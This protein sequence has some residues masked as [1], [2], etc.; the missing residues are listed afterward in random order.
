MLTKRDWIAVLAVT[1]CFLAATLESELVTVLSLCATAIVLGLV[2]KLTREQVLVI[3]FGFS[4]YLVAPDALNFSPTYLAL[5]TFWLSPSFWVVIF[6]SQLL[7]RLA[8]AWLTW[9]ATLMV[10]VLISSSRHRLVLELS[11]LFDL[12]KVLFA[13]ALGFTVAVLAFNSTAAARLKLV[14]LWLVLSSSVAG[15]SLFAFFA[16][17]L[18]PSSVFE[19]FVFYNLEPNE[20]LGGSHYNARLR[21]TFEDPNLFALYLLI[22]LI[23][24]L[25]TAA[26]TVSTAS[27]TQTVALSAALSLADS[28]AATV[29]LLASI[30]FAT[31]RVL[32]LRT[33]L[34]S[35]LLWCGVSL[36]SFAG[37]SFAARIIFGVPDRISGRARLSEDAPPPEGVFSDIRWALWRTALE[38][39]STEP[40]IGIGFGQFT[41]MADSGGLLVHNTFLSF[42]AELG[43]IGLTVVA[44]PALLVVAPS[45]KHRNLSV[46]VTSSMLFGALVMANV[47]NLE[48]SNLLWCVFALALTAKLEAFHPPR[49]D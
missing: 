18:L 22:S 4:M 35:F 34:P 41:E 47:Y 12:S 17:W 20:A 25:F 8:G 7:R 38:L 23:L 40:L 13:S 21:G 19:N 48:N 3:S 36:V 31:T 2:L 26:Q 49:N 10:V 33:F 16:N 45:R 42:L 37:T 43:L 1:G 9:T 15:F 30:G 44:L 46:A 11:S 5:V 28:R 24:A 14:R 6:R 27:L 32:R 29:A 39:W